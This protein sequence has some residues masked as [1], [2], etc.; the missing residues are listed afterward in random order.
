MIETVN[1]L[2]KILDGLSK[3]GRGDMPLKGCY[4]YQDMML[5]IRKVDANNN[6]AIFLDLEQPDDACKG[7]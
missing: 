1:D 3:D 5:E 4:L 2:K 7:S 6:H